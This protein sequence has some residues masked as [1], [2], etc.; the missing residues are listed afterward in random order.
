MKLENV[1]IHTCTNFHLTIFN[2]QFLLCGPLE[3]NNQM[4]E[5]LHME[6]QIQTKLPISHCCILRA[7]ITE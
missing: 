7:H 4:F 3:Y 1:V 5:K 6:I 2:V